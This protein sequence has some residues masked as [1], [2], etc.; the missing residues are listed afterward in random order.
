MGFQVAASLNGNHKTPDSMSQVTRQVKDAGLQDRLVKKKG[1]TKMRK[2]NRH[3]IL[4]NKKL[5]KYVMTDKSMMLGSKEEHVWNIEIQSMC[6]HLLSMLE[7][8]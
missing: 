4:S 7:E 6:C 8:M 1:K 5:Q 3:L 2:K